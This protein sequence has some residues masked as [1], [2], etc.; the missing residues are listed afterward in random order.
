MRVHKVCILLVLILLG[1]SVV[2]PQENG[3]ET[4]PVVEDDTH[5]PFCMALKTNMLYDALLVPN[6]G[7]EF[8]LG[9][10]FAV[11]AN[12][13]YAWWSPGSK[14][15]SWRIYG[16]DINFR[17]YLGRKAKEKPLQGHHVGVYAQAYTYDFCLGGKGIMG[18]VPGG[19][20][21]DK[22]NYGV[23]VEY[24]YSMP[25]AKRLNIDF[26]LGLGY[27]GGEYREYQPADNHYVWQATK[28]RDFFGPTKAEVTLVWVLGGKEKGGGR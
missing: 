25:V 5:K 4:G 12:W 26:T 17:K 20:I 3:S 24:G 16:G 10:G 22:L 11:G 23:G 9:K 15:N 7:V 2:Y 28:K 6:L 1:T 13:M 8:H 19:N 14:T 18:G 21:L 27:F